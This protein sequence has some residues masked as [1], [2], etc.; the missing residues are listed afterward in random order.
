MCQ[1]LA[2]GYLNLSGERMSHWVYIIMIVSWLMFLLLA[3]KI[4]MRYRSQTSFEDVERYV[5]VALLVTAVVVAF[6]I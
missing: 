5:A 1:W 6:L 4:L 3:R 2:V